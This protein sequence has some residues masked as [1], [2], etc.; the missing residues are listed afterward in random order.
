[1]HLSLPTSW[2]IGAGAAPGTRTFHHGK[3]TAIPFETGTAGFQ[4]SPE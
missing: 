2:H 3:Q 1:M 4:L